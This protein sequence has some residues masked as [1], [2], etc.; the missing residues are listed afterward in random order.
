MIVLCYLNSGMGSM[1]IPT[2]D[3][4]RHKVRIDADYF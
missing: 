3:L 2:E 1:N 4:S